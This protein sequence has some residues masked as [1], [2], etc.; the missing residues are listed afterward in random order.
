MPAMLEQD[1]ENLRG[2]GVQLREGLLEDELPE[3][4]E[5]CG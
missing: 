1:G 2:D 4:V 3:G 5:R